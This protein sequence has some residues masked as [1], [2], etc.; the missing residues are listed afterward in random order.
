M[1]VPFALTHQALSD[2]I[3][4]LG[5][6]SKPGFARI[7]PGLV[8]KIMEIQILESS[9][10]P[11]LVERLTLTQS[12]NAICKRLSTLAGV[13]ITNSNDIPMDDALEDIHE[14][15]S[16]RKAKAC[17]SNHG[18]T[19]DECKMALETIDCW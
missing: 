17:P 18:L 7:S 6:M 19:E 3:K 2:C 11:R 14:S 12:P 1:Y 4:V 5:L 13:D 9:V 15:F 8:S 10:P 16:R